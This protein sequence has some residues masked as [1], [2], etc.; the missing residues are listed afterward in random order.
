MKK[1]LLVM[2]G[3]HKSGANL[4]LQG[5]AAVWQVASQLA[6][7]GHVPFFPGIDQ[8]SDLW[9]ENGLRLQI[10]CAT[11]RVI[12][13]QNYPEGAYGFQLRRN[14]WMSNE[15][16]TRRSSLRPYS[17]V[18][19]FFVLWGIDENRFFILP[20][21]HAGQAIWF[22]P[23]FYHSKSNNRKVFGLITEQRLADME[24][25]WDLLDVSTTSNALIE[26]ADAAVKETV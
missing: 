17:E 24:D 8:G 19:D 12:K 9:L 14:V 15:K 10:K 5:Q 6:L 11:L 20:T 7:R 23:K 4:A 13:G 2:K 16:K 25:R 18:A 26:S 21:I 3:T 1:E 22:A